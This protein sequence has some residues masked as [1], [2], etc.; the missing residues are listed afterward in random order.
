MSFSLALRDCGIHISVL[1]FV[2][3]V[4]SYKPLLFRLSSVSF[5]NPLLTWM[6]FTYL[7]IAERPA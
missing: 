5:W 3:T 1:C 6:N 7:G 4:V 2:E